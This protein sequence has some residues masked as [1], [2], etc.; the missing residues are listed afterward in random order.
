MKIQII[1]NIEALIYTVF[2]LEFEIENITQY[3]YVE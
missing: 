2:G 1:S 3:Q